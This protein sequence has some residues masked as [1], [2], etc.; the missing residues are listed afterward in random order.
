MGNIINLWEFISEISLQISYN[1]N[2]KSKK[3]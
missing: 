3:Y 1:N 2:A